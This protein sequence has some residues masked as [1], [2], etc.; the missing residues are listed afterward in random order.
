MKVSVPV[1]IPIGSMQ[2]RFGY[3]VLSSEKS[4]QRLMVKPSTPGR[5][6]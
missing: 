2:V 4:W 5:L 6:K 1:E 3:H